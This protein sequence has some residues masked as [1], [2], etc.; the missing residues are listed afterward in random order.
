MGR[1]IYTQKGEF[2]WKYVF[3]EQSSEQYRIAEELGIGRYRNREIE[4]KRD[5]YGDMLSLSRKD[6]ETLANT[7][8]PMRKLLADYLRA[9]RK[10]TH[11][12]GNSKMKGIIVPQENGLET[13]VVKGIDV[14]AVEHLSQVV[15]FLNDIQDIAPREVDVE[16]LFNRQSTYAVDFSDVKGQEHTKRAIEVAAAGGHNLIMVGPPGAGK[17]M[18]AKCIPNIT[19]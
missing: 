11:P 10:I 15:D 13:A 7:V 2:V 9:E 4:N 5:P 1:R 16:A 14:L 18:L 19:S 17:T 8:K 3:G 12:I 6:V